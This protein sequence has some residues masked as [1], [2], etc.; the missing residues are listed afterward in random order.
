MT[1][2]DLAALQDRAYKD[3]R[4][5]SAADFKST[6]AQPTTHLEHSAQGFLIAQVIPDEA[7]ILALATDPHHQR[8][9]GLSP[10]GA[11]RIGD[12]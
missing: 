8:R 6:L 10:A 5:W 3:M 2:Q 7:E 1:P 12:A 4:P 11:F 9:G